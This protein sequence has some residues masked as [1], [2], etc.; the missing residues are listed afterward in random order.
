M[1]RH[2]K[3]SSYSLDEYIPNRARRQNQRPTRSRPGCC[4]RSVS[5]A[6]RAAPPICVA[7]DLC[8]SAQ[9]CYNAPVSHRHALGAFR[10][11]WLAQKF[12]FS[13]KSNFFTINPF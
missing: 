3:H 7:A 9:V 11:G 13:E 10:F 4:A 2:E 8:P 5:T 1:L 12:D 6:R